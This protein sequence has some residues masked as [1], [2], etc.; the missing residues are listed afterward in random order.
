MPAYSAASVRAAVEPHQKRYMAIWG[1]GRPENWTPSPATR[2][3]LCLGMWLNEEMARVGI[4]D[5][6]RRM[7]GHRFN[8]KSSSADDLFGLAAELLNEAVE[9]RIPEKP[10]R[11]RWGG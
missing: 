10:A 3:T 6:D 7:Q 4:N 11:T 2:D 9:G 1:E 5:D 8:R